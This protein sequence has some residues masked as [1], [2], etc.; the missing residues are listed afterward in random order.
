MIRTDPGMCEGPL[1]PIPGPFRYADGDAP[2]KHFPSGFLTGLLLTLLAGSA[3]GQDTDSEP[4]EV[5]EPAPVEQ[6]RFQSRAERDR[7]LLVDAHPGEAQL[8]EI[9]NGTLLA[10]YRPAL[11]AQPRG[12]LLLAY[13]GNPPGEWP[14]YWENLRHVLPEQGWN[15]LALTLPPPVPTPVA[16][17][18][19]DPAPEPQGSAD[20]S[21]GSAIAPENT[22][23]EES[24]PVVA[25]PAVPEP[26]ISREQRI[27]AR[28][29]AAIAFLQQQ[30]SDNLALLVNASG[31]EEALEHLGPG[32]RV[33][34]AD[35]GQGQSV[36]AG[37]VRALILVNLHSHTVLTEQQL[38]RIFAVPE[39]PVLDLFLGMESPPRTEQRKFHKG[40][41]R[42][43]GLSQ[44]RA[45]LLP[46]PAAPD[47]NDNQSFWV[48]RI[49]SFL[50][51]QL[52]A[53]RDG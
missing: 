31:A 30:E 44:Y 50:D 34:E 12:T 49:E 28:L 22:A 40:L 20:E 17:R 23:D 24:D 27:A 29:D 37:P 38:L 47:P 8:L 13:A 32:L 6:P 26:T 46:N 9:P 45:L 14:A 10:L 36:L 43:Q 7:Q 4:Q 15:T 51:R 53:S 2:M 33:D 42:R 48:R 35:I 52:S 5:E 19:P 3:L 21:Q 41:A 16:K 25:E 1:Y 18:P 39:L 11:A